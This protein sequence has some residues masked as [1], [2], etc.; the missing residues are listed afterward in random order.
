MKYSCFLGDKGDALRLD[1]K[2][3]GGTKQWTERLAKI[4]NPGNVKLQTRNGKVQFGPGLRFAVSLEKKKKKVSNL[5]LLPTL[6]GKLPFAYWKRV[7]RTAF[8]DGAITITCDTY[9]LYHG[10]GGLKYRLKAEA[11]H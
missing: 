1:E 11:S 7:G 4:W 5:L 3:Q 10:F 8:P 6:N 2:Q 9:K